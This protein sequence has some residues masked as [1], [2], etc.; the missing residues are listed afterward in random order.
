MKVM[1]SWLMMWCC[2]QGSFFLTIKEQRLIDFQ[3][4]SRVTCWLSQWGLRKGD[5]V[6]AQRDKPW[7]SSG[8]EDA[9]SP[10]PHSAISAS[11]I[12]ATAFI[13]AAMWNYGPLH[14][15]MKSP[16]SWQVQPAR[17]NIPNTAVSESKS[18][19]FEFNHWKVQVL[20]NT[21]ILHVQYE[22]S[23]RQHLGRQ[24]N[25]ATQCAALQASWEA[26]AT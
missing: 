25:H 18:R 23:P 12:A 3:W 10:R 24:G 20:I 16:R 6:S 4:C 19:A 9:V 17:T 1:L 21:Q 2:K 8:R 15:V 22:F 13:T 5:H 7:L 11:Q 26:A 14:L